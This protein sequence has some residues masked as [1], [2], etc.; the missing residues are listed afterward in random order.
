MEV[1]IQ[2]QN[3]LSVR[4]TKIYNVCIPQIKGFTICITYTAAKTLGV[5]DCIN[6]KEHEKP[7]QEVLLLQIMVVYNN[8]LSN[9]ISSKLRLW[10][11][12]IVISLTPISYKAHGKINTLA[13]D[14]RHGGWWCG[15]QL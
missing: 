8:Y 7:I 15:L 2:E 4:Y 12:I 11:Y 3:A 10:L 13:G 6:P 9:T 5:T 1:I 14:K